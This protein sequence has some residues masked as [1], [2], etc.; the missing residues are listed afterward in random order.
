MEYNV[1]F[2][3]LLTLFA[4][5]A[6]V[7]GSFIAFFAKKSKAG[8]LSFGLG[9]SG[10]VMVYISFVEILVKSKESVAV[11]TGIKTGGWI[12]VGSFFLGFLITA[13]IDKFIPEHENPMRHQKRNM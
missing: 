6:T 4:G 3:F 10:G 13:L 9:F 2:A 5:L 11:L 8:I 1:L 7:G 12:A